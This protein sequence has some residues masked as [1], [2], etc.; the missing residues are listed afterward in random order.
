[1]APTAYW[2]AKEEL[3]LVDFLVAH[4]AEA[5]DGGSFKVTTFQKAANYLAPMLERGAAKNAKSCGN[6]YCAVRH[7]SYYLLSLITDCIA[8]SKALSSNPRNPVRFGMDLG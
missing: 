7:I 6:K 3:A 4:K 2:T 5:N 1:M 8:V